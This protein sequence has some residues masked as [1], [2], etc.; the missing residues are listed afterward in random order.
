MFRDKIERNK[1]NQEK[2]KKKPIKKLGTILYQIE[3]DEN[4]KKI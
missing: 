1:T 4:E 3:M 2:D